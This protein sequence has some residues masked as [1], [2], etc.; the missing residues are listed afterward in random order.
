MAAVLPATFAL[1][2]GAH[3]FYMAGYMGLKV[4]E[5]LA[6]QPVN[7][8]NDA[9]QEKKF[10]GA[11]GF[12][13]SPHWRL[14]SELSYRKDEAQSVNSP[15]A[16]HMKSFAGLVN[17]YSDFDA[18]GKIKPFIG[19]GAGY[20]SKLSEESSGDNKMVWQLG[21]G[22]NYAISPTLSLNSAYRY[23]DQSANVTNEGDNYGGHEFHVGVTYALS[24]K[25]APKPR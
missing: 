3:G 14:E 2:D 18:P 16:D 11:L 6:S 24:Y 10:A 25:P 23:I 22:I 19:G 4:P 12:R 13:L 15:L 9:G 7:F 20:V 17:L 5:S 1:A 21:G 8:S